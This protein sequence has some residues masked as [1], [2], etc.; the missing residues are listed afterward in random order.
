[1]PSCLEVQTWRVSSPAEM[2]AFL[3]NGEKGDGDKRKRYSLSVRVHLRPVDVYAYLKARFGEPNGFQNIL[4]RDDSDNLVHWDFFLWAG[5]N[6]IYLAGSSR[7]TMI[8]TTEALS[9]LQWKQLIE[10]IKADFSRFAKEK[11]AVLRSFEKYV[12]FQNKY[13]ALASLCAELHASIVDMPPA[14]ELVPLHGEQGDTKSFEEVMAQ[15]SRRLTQLYGDC[16]KL[17]LLMPV[18]AEAYINMIILIFCRDAIRNDRTAYEAFLRTTIPERLELLSVNC[19]GFAR[20]VDKTVGGWDDF[21]RV[22]SRRN[23][24]LHGNVD[25][26]KEQIEVVYFEGRRPLFVHPGHSIHLQFERTEKAADAA[27]LLDEYVDL[28]GFLANVAQ[29]M[30]K[31]H[32]AFFEQVI[33]DAYPGYELFKRRATRLFPD[34]YVWHGTDGM[35]YDDELEVDW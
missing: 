7:E 4:R 17:R 24:E 28:H 27:A 12:V 18:M 15:R 23:F 1:M 34:H 6:V 32:K 2:L 22:V 31:R 35:R 21:M 8:M 26:I 10:A 20:A 11:S 25:P 30:T 9:D 19:D 13:V 29:C 16:L 14:A 3:G 33:G 5:D